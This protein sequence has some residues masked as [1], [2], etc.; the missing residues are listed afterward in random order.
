MSFQFLILVLFSFVW[1][2]LIFYILKGM[3]GQT[4]FYP[5]NRK[6]LKN[7]YKDIKGLLPKNPNFV[8]IGSGDGRIVAWAS[9]KGMNATGIESN[10][11]LTLLSRL[12]LLITRS[13]G[14]IINANFF[15]INY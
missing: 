8:D 1:L 14:K 6:K 2:G 9:N 7:L 12:I 5:S 10:P 15:K 4:P 3:L 11:Y 13:K